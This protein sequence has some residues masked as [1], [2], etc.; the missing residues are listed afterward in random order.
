ML[1]VAT[2]VAITGSSI[3]VDLLLFKLGKLLPMSEKLVS[4]AMMCQLRIT[5]KY[6]S[7]EWVGCCDWNSLSPHGLART[8]LSC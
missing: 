4:G 3:D 7:H 1:R 8:A 5:A 6:S 2:I